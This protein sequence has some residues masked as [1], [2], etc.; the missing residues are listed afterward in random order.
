VLASA[1]YTAASP[2]TRH[3]GGASALLTL[4]RKPS[5]NS[6]AP[7]AI[8]GHSL[9]HLP[10]CVAATLPWRGAST[11]SNAGSGECDWMSLDMMTF[12]SSWS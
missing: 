12:A 6:P 11:A 1:Q 3:R 7:Q 4:L 9:S 8:T 2:R 5:E 10:F